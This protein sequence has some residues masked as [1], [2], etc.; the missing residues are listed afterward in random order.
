MREG[1][2]DGDGGDGGKCKCKCHDIDGPAY[3]LGVKEDE[4]SQFQ[5]FGL[6]RGINATDDA[7]WKNKSS[8][9]V[10]AVTKESILMTEEG[11]FVRSYEDVVESVQ[12]IWSKLNAS[13]TDGKY[14]TIGVD[15]EATRVYSTR[16]ESFGKKIVTRTVSF[17]TNLELVGGSKSKEPIEKL[18][19]EYVSSEQSTQDK[20]CENF[21]ERYKV[22]HYVSRIELGALQYRVMD[23]ME[24]NT[25][26]K[27]KTTLEIMD[28]AALSIEAG[29][30]KKLDRIATHVTEIGHLEGKAVERGTTNE[31]VVG[32]SFEPI[33][34]LIKDDT[35]RD[36]FK[37]A[38][39]RYL[40][41]RKS[42]C[43]FPF[44][45]YDDIVS[46]SNVM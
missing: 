29:K 4:E 24:Y 39:Q 41:K 40:E 42:K 6:G 2:G 15:C 32:V 25:N 13:M 37:T 44:T 43:E 10:R 12:D 33:S 23:K 3:E 31:A 9:Q 5:D 16:K 35:L 17:K 26:Y 20:A 30:N 14:V 18:I 21:I 19:E 34:T 22:T 11:G 45:H 8:V 28:L 38:T 27:A 1:N 36:R 7:P 46:S